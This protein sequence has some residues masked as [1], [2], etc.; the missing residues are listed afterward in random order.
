VIPQA[1]FALARLYAAQGNPEAAYS[2]FEG[3]ATDERF[4][5]IGSEAGMRAEE[6]RNKYPQL[7]P[8]PEM[9]TPGAMNMPIVITNT[10]SGA[11][12]TSGTGAA[13][14]VTAP[15]APGSAAAK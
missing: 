3:L 8:K 15:V 12:T 11:A 9:P 2:L 7:A 4:T 14:T 5:S 10:S 1:K 13:V 6:L